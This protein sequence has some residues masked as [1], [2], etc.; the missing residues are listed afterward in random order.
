MS[1]P[2]PIRI[3]VRGANGGEVHSVPIGMD[4]EVYRANWEAKHAQST[5]ER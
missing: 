2:T 1:A 3:K 5:V 4:P